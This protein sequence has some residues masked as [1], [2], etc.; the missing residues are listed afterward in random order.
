LEVLSRAVRRV[1]SVFAVFARAGFM[2]A[3][4]MAL[5]ASPLESRTALASGEGDMNEAAAAAA[6]RF[7]T[8]AT[9]IGP[10]M[11]LTA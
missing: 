5:V 7:C 9:I 1:D 3:L 11:T 6:L 8:H 2:V 10:V 4:V